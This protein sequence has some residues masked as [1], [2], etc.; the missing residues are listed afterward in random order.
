MTIN[1]L[2]RLPYDAGPSLDSAL[3]ATSMVDFERALADTAAVVEEIPVDD[4]L[5]ARL[6]DRVNALIDERV[7][8]DAAAKRP[9]MAREDKQ[10]LA[11]HLIT[12]ELETELFDAAGREGRPVMSGAEEAETR[13]QVLDSIFGIG[14][15]LE[16][17]LQI[18]EVE[19]I[20]IHGAREVILRFADGRRERRPRVAD[21]DKD[22][23]DQLDMIATHHGQHARAVTSARPWLNMQLPDGS[24]LAA[25]WDI[26]PH[27]RITI[28]KHRFM[29]PTLADLVG[30]GMISQ[31]MAE[32]LK[33]AVLAKRTIFFVGDGAMGK[34]TMMRACAYC[35]PREAS[36]ATIETERELGLHNDPDRFPELISYE[37]RQGMGER[38]ASGRVTGEISLSDIF[39]TTLKHSLQRVLLGEVAESELIDLLIAAS[40]GLR[41]SM[42]TVHAYSAKGALDAMVGTVLRHS[43]NLTPEAAMHMVAAAADIIVYIDREMTA[44]GPLRYVAEILEVGSMSRDSRLPDTTWIFAPRPELVEVDPRGYPQDKPADPLWARR[45]GFDMDWLDKPRHPGEEDRGAWERPFPRRTLG[46]AGTR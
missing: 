13:R 22:L 2:R 36:F 12:R 21:S 40:R 4:A 9:P 41:G 3:D 15:R 29:N 11:M 42:A 38:D 26:V 23:L 43:T 27:P 34:T 35:L 24:R 14:S 28:R 8:Q 7:A 16:K 25:V 17:L 5:V 31:A 6:R 44:E 45:V 1:P 37:A 10:Q 18:P 30:M 33:A 19:D 20:V 46:S 39:P 32:F